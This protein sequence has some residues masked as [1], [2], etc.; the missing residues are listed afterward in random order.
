[1][2][3]VGWSLHVLIDYR[4]KQASRTRGKREWLQKLP[5]S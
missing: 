4:L 1:M 5:D 3:A 2:A